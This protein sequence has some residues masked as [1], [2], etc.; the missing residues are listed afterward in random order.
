MTHDIIVIEKDTAIPARFI[1][2]IHVE[3]G[4]I[5]WMLRIFM[6][7]GL[8]ALTITFATEKTA[9]EVYDRVVRDL[10]AYYTE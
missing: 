2:A 6:T 3:K 9:R 1:G 4:E 10:A 8:P 7:D 5:G